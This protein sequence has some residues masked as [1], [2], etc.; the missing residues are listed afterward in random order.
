[1]ITFNLVL[2]KPTFGTFTIWINYG[3]SCLLVLWAICLYSVCD[4]LSYVL[5]EYFIRYTVY[6]QEMCGM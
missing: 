2:M 4:T 5:N 3:V 1:M 6:L